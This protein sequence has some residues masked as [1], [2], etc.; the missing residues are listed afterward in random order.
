MTHST[1]HPTR[2][3]AMM[4]AA[5]A[6]FAL[7]NTLTQYIA[8]QLHLPGPTIAF[9]QYLAATALAL[10]WALSRSREAWAMRRPGLHLM[11]AGCAVA[12]VQLWVASLAFVPIWQASAL[13][14]LSPFFVTLGAALILREPTPP[15]RW[16]AVLGGLSGGMILLA[17]WSEA[18]TPAALMPVGAAA[19]W[20]G[21]SLLTKR[22][23]RDEA[24]E[25]LTL[26]LLLL[27]TPANAVLALL[28]L[29]EGAPVATL[30][31]GGTALALL[32][33]A[34]VLTAVAQ[35]AIARAYSLADAGYLQPFDHVKLP[36]NV[37]LGVLAFGFVPPGSMW[38]GSAL[39]VAAS[40]YLLE[41][42][43]RGAA[44]A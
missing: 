35:Y 43:R 11:R 8:M 7:Y 12:G 39:I 27:L 20:A 40:F 18:F 1:Q 19:L 6:I 42:E 14:L 2:G 3:A 29:P 25:A 31:P 5:G 33:L 16:L 21:T 38:A 34:G 28:A 30:V 26:H 17:P 41:Q 15:R 32:L 36:L 24:P 22:L 13:I 44:T 23:T 9:W 37:G 10:P 4:I